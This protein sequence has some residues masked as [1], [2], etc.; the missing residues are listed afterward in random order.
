[1]L[2]GPNGETQQIV[3]EFWLKNLS[4]VAEGKII[5]ETNEK[6]VANERFGSILSS[7]LSNVAENST[8]APL[9][10]PR[11]DTELFFQRKNNMIKDVEV[12]FEKHHHIH[13]ILTYHHIH[14]YCHFTCKQLNLLC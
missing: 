12:I 9:D 3:G 8:F 4:Q 10:I 5:V 1:M 11:W 6:G 14:L 13:L 2:A 7:Y